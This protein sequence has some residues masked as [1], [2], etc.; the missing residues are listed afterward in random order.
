M[1]RRSH[2]Y[3]PEENRLHDFEVRRAAQ[4]GKVVSKLPIYGES[5]H[6]SFEYMGQ[7]ND[8]MTIY[9]QKVALAVL[10]RLRACDQ[11]L[12]NQASVG[13]GFATRPE[14]QWAD[15]PGDIPEN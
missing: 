3:A 1:L 4:K 15:Q 5:F 10:A 12:N 8:V 9:G 14:D 6:L 13:D 11:V 2:D 7:R